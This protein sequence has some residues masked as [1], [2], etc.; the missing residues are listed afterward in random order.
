MMGL[1]SENNIYIFYIFSVRMMSGLHPLVDARLK[2]Y[3]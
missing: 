2:K 1:K 3:A